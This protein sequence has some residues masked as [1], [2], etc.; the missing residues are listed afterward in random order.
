MTSGIPQYDALYSISDLHLGGPPGMQMFRERERLGGFARWLAGPGPEARNCALVLAGDVIDSLP[1][2]SGTGTY[3]AV[4]GAAALV[5]RIAHDFAPVFEGWRA[6]V[7]AEGRELVVLI[8]NHDLELAL[9]EAQHAFLHAVGGDDPKARG[10]VRFLTDGTGFRCQVGARSV[11]VTH[12]NEADPWN[13]VDHEML[14]RVAHLR[15]LG[16]SFDREEWSPNAG[17]RLVVDVMNEIKR[18]H[19]FVDVLKPETEVMTRVLAALDSSVLGRFFAALPAFFQREWKR[20][21]PSV[22]LGTPPA[23]REAHATEALQLLSAAASGLTERPVQRDA[24]GAALMQRVREAHAEGRRPEELVQ[25]GGTNLGWGTYFADLFGGLSKEEALRRALLDWTKKDRTFSMRD[26]DE[27]CRLIVSQVG[28]GTDVV[29]T[30]HTH[31]ARWIELHDRS[32]MV[33]LNAGTW[34]RIIA[35]DDELLGNAKDFKTV[36]DALAKG[37]MLVL[38]ELQ[39]SYGKQKRPLVLAA[40][41][42]ARVD[43]NGAALVRVTDNGSIIVPVDPTEDPRS[44]QSNRRD[45]S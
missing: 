12:G 13:H 39:V 5:E 34:A 31:L 30:G 4:D 26:V 16:H 3:I 44:W 1:S 23:A 41:L 33:Y 45:R 20:T 22:V 10:R 43:F 32:D 11:Y 2:M 38:D 29:I 35:F 8:G 42:A 21:G 7:A 36:Y 15:S 24:D 37:D 6:F 17:T 18:K 25:G 9:P 19:P 27:T 40:T 28:R 14:R